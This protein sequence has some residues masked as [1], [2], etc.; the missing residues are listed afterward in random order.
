MNN[1]P[2]SYDI[3]NKNNPKSLCSTCHSRYCKEHKIT[4]FEFTAHKEFCLTCYLYTN[5]LRPGPRPKKFMINS[6]PRSESGTFETF[7]ALATVNQQ[8]QILHKADEVYQCNICNKLLSL[9]SV[10]TPCDH[11]FCAFCI[12]KLF[13]AIRK[14]SIQCFCCSYNFSQKDLNKIPQ[15]IEHTITMV[16]LQCR[17]C[18]EQLVLNGTINHICK[19]NKEQAFFKIRNAVQEIEEARAENHICPTELTDLAHKLVHRETQVSNGK[20]SIKTQGRPLKMVT[21]SKTETVKVISDIDKQ[22]MDAKRC[23][24]IMNACKIN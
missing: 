11:F 1:R 9:D 24:G 5:Q 14:S 17:K 8:F 15:I 19:S 6:N 2:A 23:L 10:K 4:P 22:K 21:E 16:P 20:L 12:N 7:S 18:K 13:K 3:N